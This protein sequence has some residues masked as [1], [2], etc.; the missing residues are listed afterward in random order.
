MLCKRKWG[1][2]SANGNATEETEMW[3]RKRK[4][5]PGNGNEE[6]EVSMGM[7]RWT[8]SL[9]QKHYKFKMYAF[10]WVRKKRHSVSTFFNDFTLILHAFSIGFSN[11]FMD[12]QK[13]LLFKFSFI[14]RCD[15]KVMVWDGSFQDG[16]LPT[17]YFTNVH[18]WGRCEN[19]TI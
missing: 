14:L 10:S 5:E 13:R 12:S 1:M 3:K 17:K 4:S 2:I 7:K 6:S 19:H 16:T 11:I 8:L 18:F 15:Q 9:S